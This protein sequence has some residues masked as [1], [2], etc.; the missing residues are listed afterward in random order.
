MRL[1]ERQ[2]TEIAVYP[3]SY[4][5][6]LSLIN[7]NVSDRLGAE[8]GTQSIQMEQSPE[9]TV[10]L[11]AGRLEDEDGTEIPIELI[12]LSRRRI[13]TKCGGTSAQ[14]SSITAKVCRFLDSLK[15]Q[16]SKVSGL[17]CEALLTTQECSI[18]VATDDSQLKNTPFAALG[19]DP[20]GI[21][22]R[23][24][25]YGAEIVLEP[26]VI[27]WRVRY[28]NLPDHY[29]EQRVTVAE[30]S[31]RVEKTGTAPDG[32]TLVRFSGPLKTDDMEHIVR[33]ALGV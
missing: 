18:V 4:V 13:L 3:P 24:P 11:T 33:M 25:T 5:P 15:P 21:V 8:F 29:S 19:N 28:R 20:L 1:V 6:F 31:I 16:D 14:A 22:S 27:S 17:S 32:E 9:P 10:L 26:S 7:R 30:K 23:I 12:A 2:S